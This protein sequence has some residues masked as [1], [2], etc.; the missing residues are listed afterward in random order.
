MQLSFTLP[1]GIS[2]VRINNNLG[3]SPARVYRSSGLAEVSKSFFKLPEDIQYFILCHEAAH[4]LYD[5]SNEFLADKIGFQ[6]YV[7][8][9][10]SLKNAVK[11]ISSTL[12]FDSKTVSNRLKEEWLQRL[13]MQLDRA[14]EFDLKNNK[15]QNQKT[16][17]RL[18]NPLKP[19]EGSLLNAIGKAAVTRIEN[20]TQ[21]KADK[22]AIKLDRKAAGV[23]NR[24]AAADRKRLRGE[25]EMI[26]AEQGIAKQNVAQGIAE[27]LGRASQEVSRYV[28]PVSGAGDALSN[29]ANNLTQ[30]GGSDSPQNTDKKESFFAKNKNYI[31]IGGVILVVAV[32]VFLFL[33]KKK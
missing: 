30:P 13:K 19:K 16:E 22:Q 6:L 3:N 23:E 32:V 21:F 7:G 12:P 31:I 10:R 5:T 4:V 20:K 15:T 25:A 29:L 24:L 11:A 2:S 28:N 26:L 27:G 14:L 18:R 8:S 33:K 17:M 1:P 9:G